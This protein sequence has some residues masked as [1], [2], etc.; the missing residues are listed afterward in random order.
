MNVLFASFEAVPFAKTGGLGDVAGSLPAALN[1]LG[2]DVRVFMPRY[3]V[4]PAGLLDGAEFLFSASVNIGGVEKY[5]G[6]S[7]L[8]RGGVT[9][10]FLDNEEHFGGDGVY[11]YGDAGA[12]QS[13]FFCRA[14]LELLPRLDFAPEILHCND[15]QT[16]LIPAMLRRQYPE[17]PLKTV[18]TIHNLQYQGIYGMDRI[19]YLTG[20]PDDCFAPGWGS[21]EFYGAADLLKGGIVYADAVNT[22]SPTYARETLTPAYGEKLEG[23]L[24]S[25]GAAYC[26]ILNGLDCGLYDPRTSRRIPANFSSRRMAGK[27]ACRRA[28]LDEFGLAAEGVPVISVVSR[29]VDQKGLDLVAGCIENVLRDGAAT[30]VVLGS[31]DPSYERFFDGLARRFP[32]RVG[33]WIGFNAELADRVYAG[34]DLFLMPSRFE[35]C[36][37][38][39]LI[40]MKFG[41]VPL[42]RETGGLSDTVTSYNEVTGRGNGFS[43]APYAAAD[44]EFTLRRAISFYTDRPDVWRTLIARCMKKDF[45]WT[46]SARRYGELYAGLTSAGGPAASSI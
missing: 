12:E 45:S 38:S 34:S 43:F 29:L 36:G 3:R 41:A 33:A 25:R 28:L 11:G 22:V 15:W 9:Y 46:A 21:L 1:A 16:A 10:Y 7:R 40:A 42:V 13:V 6:I 37:L 4:I 24:A 19:R 23:V 20:L 8:V 18:L 26:G 17:R 39:Q 14:L 27:A 5:A 32:R 30:L 44:L 2:H 35:P 31:G